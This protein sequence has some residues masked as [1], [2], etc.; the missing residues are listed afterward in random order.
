MNKN[1]KKSL[2]L[3]VCSNNH[4]KIWKKN[5]ESHYKYADK[6]NIVYKKLVFS[7]NFSVLEA[8][9]IKILSLNVFLKQDFE[10]IILIDTDCLIQDN[11][12]DFFEQIDPN[13]SISMALGYSGNYNSGIL[14][15]KNNSYSNKFINNLIEIM[16][17]KVSHADWGE[18]GHIIH[19]I[20]TKKLKI[21]ALDTKWNN[22]I[23]IYKQD[24]FRHFSAGGGMRESYNFSLTAKILIFINRYRESFNNRLMPYKSSR[25]GLKM[26]LTK[27]INL[28]DFKI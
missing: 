9:W 5:I 26:R 12:P 2:L 7:N 13:C 28:H 14:Y 18:N 22:N 21:C 6:Y 17:L 3:C 16:D 15:L 24:Y 25:N 10:N 27:I 19:L 8:S 1:S 11:A 23:S 4:D 20:K